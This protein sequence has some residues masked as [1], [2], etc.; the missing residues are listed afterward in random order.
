MKISCLQSVATLLLSIATCTSPTLAASFCDFDGDGMSDIPLVRRGKGGYNWFAYDPRTGKT[1]LLVRS[2]GSASSRLIP[3]NWFTSK[4]AVPAVVHRPSGGVDHKGMLLPAVWSAKS[5]TY[6]GGLTR[7]RS[8]GRS[9]DI[10]IL[11]GDYDGNGIT[12]S[13]L[14]KRTT[15]KLG[16]RV[17]YFLSSYNGDNLGGERLYRELGNP[18]Q[19]H[20]FFFSPD[21]ISDYLAVLQRTGRS[22]SA[23]QLKPF[24]DTPT[25]FSLGKLPR[26]AQGPL[27]LKRGEGVADWLLFYVPKRQS[28]KLIVKNLQGT[29]VFRETISGSTDIAVGDYFDDSGWEIAVRDGST[30]RF[31]NPKTRGEYLVDDLPRGRVVSCI[32][33]QRIS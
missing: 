23:L 33:N 26:K 29:T 25:S 18:F 11:G 9:G 13:L 22:V 5:V 8:L 30:L 15:E 19:D 31:I 2:L 20:N 21:G 17:N 4:L 1:K 27:P 7:T 32:S 16:L 12:D 14:L 24:T 10:V 28:T 6:A 3:G